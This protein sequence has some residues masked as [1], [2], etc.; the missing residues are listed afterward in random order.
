MSFP[1]LGGSK[2]KTQIL[3]IDECE[4]CHNRVTHPHQPGD[5]VY[6]PAGECD[7]CHGTRRI[8]MVYSEDLRGK[9][10]HLTASE[11]RAPPPSK[12]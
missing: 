3:T 5:Y 4:N 8:I 12:P 10:P 9:Q 2:P 11:P 6:K 7:K 1:S